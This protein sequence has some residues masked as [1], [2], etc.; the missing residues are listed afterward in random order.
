MDLERLPAWA[1]VLLALAAGA[2]CQLLLG[3]S[4]LAANLDPLG[5]EG[6][7]PVAVVVLDQGDAGAALL[8]RLQANA[9]PVRWEGVATREEAL[10]GLAQKRY[11]GALVLPENLTEALGS[12]ATGSPHAALVETYTNPGATTSGNLIAARA[13]ELAVEA[14]R[15]AARARALAGA[16]VATT[17]LGALSL[18]QGRFLAEPV[19][20]RAT[21][22][23]P[24]PAGG[25]NGLAPTY[26]AMAAW[27]GGYLGAVALERFRPV[28]K[29]RPPRRALLMAGA[30]L[31]QA[32][33]ATGAAMA[34]GLEARDAAALALVLT[35]GTWMAYALV[36]LLTD[37]IGIA[38]V[39]PAFAVLAL[40]LPASGAV[41]P[42]GL[43]PDFYQALHA[44]NPFTWLLEALRTVLYAPRA[45]DLGGHLWALAGLAL[46]CTAASLVLGLARRRRA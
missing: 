46:A 41:Y 34:I 39:L 29:L 23:N 18:E 7:V 11:H 19:H 16:D 15:D 21:V 24:V 31:V 28:T 44:W 27:I 35:A 45:P 25:A 17:G 32:A 8:S 1:L 5:Q 12:F 10:Q 6:G 20:A 33:L 4:Y 37:L 3:T 38:A 42:V 2:T 13:A 30:S 40:G 26:F 9:S 14:L 36:A 22:V 43:L